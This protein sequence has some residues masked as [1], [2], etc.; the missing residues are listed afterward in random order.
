VRGQPTDVGGANEVGGVAPGDYP[1]APTA[2]ECGRPIRPSLRPIR[3]FS[4][5]NGPAATKAR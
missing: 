5:P 3:P 2:A 1:P 4:D